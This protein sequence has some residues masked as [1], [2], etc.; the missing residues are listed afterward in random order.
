MLESGLY[1]LI[2]E[3]GKVQRCKGRLGLVEDVFWREEDLS[4]MPWGLAGSIP[5]P[6]YGAVDW[7]AHATGY[8]GEETTLFR[9]GRLH[10]KG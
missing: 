7:E 8:E 6:N 4:M 1:S 9:A 10:M 5:I 3:A 2:D